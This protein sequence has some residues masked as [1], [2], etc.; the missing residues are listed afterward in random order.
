MVLPEKGKILAFQNTSEILAFYDCDFYFSTQQSWIWKYLLN[1]RRRNR[2]VKVIVSRK[3]I[4]FFSPISTGKSLKNSIS[5]TEIL[6]K[7]LLLPFLFFFN[8]FFL[9]SLCLTW[10]WRFENL[11]EITYIHQGLC[12]RF[13]LTL[14]FSFMWNG[15]RL[16]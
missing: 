1:T 12:W 10:S 3:Q 15:I 4:N 9:F 16:R 7:R 14:V 5:G 13:A 6:E 2:C 8:F 11:F